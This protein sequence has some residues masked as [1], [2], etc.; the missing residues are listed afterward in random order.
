VPPM[1]GLA[2]IEPGSLKVIVG[3][4]SG[5]T[6]CALRGPAWVRS[7]I[8]LRSNFALCEASHNAQFERELIHERIRSGIA[9]AKARQA[10]RPPAGTSDQ[11]PTGSPQSPYASQWGAV[12]V[13]LAVSC[14]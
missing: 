11:N 12:I 1:S 8:R 5:P 10:P 9:A 3:R 14:G 2:A 6:A 13:S 4:V 7:R